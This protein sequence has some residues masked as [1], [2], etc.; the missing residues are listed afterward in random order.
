MKKIAAI[1]VLV[2]LFACSDKNLNQPDPV[3]FYFDFAQGT[4]GWTGDFADYP[5]GEEHFYDLV[6]EH[7][8]L[9]EP[10]DQNQFALKL[11]GNNHSDD[12]F[13]FAKRKVSGLEPNTVYY[14]NFTLEF[15]TNV[16]DGTMGAGG[17]PGESVYIKAGATTTEPKKEK[18]G[19]NFYRMNIDKNNQSQNGE[20]MVVIGDFSNDT[21]LEEYTLKSVSNESPFGAATDE[22]GNLWLIIGTDSGFE[23]TTTIYYNSVKVECF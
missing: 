8:T 13:M 6:F 11:S 22:N 4:D 2:V 21:D 17:S 18:D 20:D 15:A 9:P 3:E 5:V 12:L 16:P 10:L 23:A 19:D 7:D 1:A 14:I